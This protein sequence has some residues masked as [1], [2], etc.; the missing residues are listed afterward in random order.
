M[1]NLVRAR[2]VYCLL[3][4]VNVSSLTTSKVGSKYST[5]RGNIKLNLFKGLFGRSDSN[6]SIQSVAKVDA[7]RVENLKQNLEKVSNIQ[8]RD[9]DAEARARA[10]TTK[11][12]ADKQVVSYNFQ[13]S[14][15]F[16]NLYKGWIKSDGDQIAKQMLVS[17]K[18]ALKKEKYIEI[19]FDPVPNLDEVSNL[20]LIF[21]KPYLNTCFCRLLS[22]L[23]TTICE[24]L[25]N[26]Y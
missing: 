1:L 10:P 7:A 12:L 22:E 16:P 24:E 13:K 25:S 18:N 2:L 15:E 23:V 9:Y 11:E 4:V 5:L 14:G 19:L 8:K 20:H 17:A 3:I 21:E 26:Y 6:A